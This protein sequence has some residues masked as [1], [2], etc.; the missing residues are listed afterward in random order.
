VVQETERDGG[1]RG[2]GGLVGGALRVECEPAEE[3]CG[4]ESTSCPQARRTGRDVCQLERRTQPASGKNRIGRPGIWQTGSLRSATR[5]LYRRTRATPSRS[6]IRR[7]TA[8]GHNLYTGLGSSDAQFI[9]HR[10]GPALAFPSTH[11]TN[12]W[13][14]TT[15]FVGV[16]A[17]CSYDAI[18]QWRSSARIVG[19]SAQRLFTNCSTAPNGKISRPIPE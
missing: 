7:G 14:T 8:G 1:T 13:A 18:D 17:K 15:K 16:S 6:T 12:S 2:W 19:H 11:P 4:A 10:P 9:D 5:T 3:L